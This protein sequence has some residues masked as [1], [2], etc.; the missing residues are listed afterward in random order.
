MWLGGNCCANNMFSGGFTNFLSL[1]GMHAVLSVLLMM[2]KINSKICIF[3]TS[4][5]GHHATANV[6]E[7]IGRKVVYIPWSDT[8]MEINLEEFTKMF[9][10]EKPDVIFLD[11]GTV[12]YPLPIKEI[13]KI[14]GD[15]ILIIY[16]GSHVLGLIAGQ[17]FQKPLEEG[18]DVLIGN[19]H[20]T[21]PGPQK[22]MMIFKNEEVGRRVSQMMLSSVV[23]SQHTHH[24]ISLYITILEMK[25]YGQAY[26]SQLIENSHALFRALS[27]Y[28]FKM[29]S[30]DNEFPKAHMLAIKGDFIEGHHMA[31]AAL[32][33]CNISTNS[34]KIFNQD[35]IR[36]GVQEI[37]RRG[38][39]EIDMKKIAYFFK[40]IILNKNQ[41][42][43]KVIHEFN[44]QFNRVEYSFDAHTN[45]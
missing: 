40:E 32:Q 8:D 35:T 1:S 38:M 26:A 11:L 5:L 44:E 27:D 7:S 21:F 24:A 45:Y 22:G 33:E 3:S 29:I 42:I 15:D 6:I 9:R 25:H 12:F 39:K 17:H 36:V 14:I 31:C 20:K 2:T 28:G 34:K 18:C 37:T 4:S 19:T 43:G 10:E 13:R 23:S 41:H 16:D 30:R